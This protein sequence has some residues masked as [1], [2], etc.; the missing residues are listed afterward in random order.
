M[1]KINPLPSKRKP[2]L[3]GAWDQELVELSS[4]EEALNICMIIPEIK[5]SIQVHQMHICS[6]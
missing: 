4:L 2:H 1:M 5:V 3:H 6:Y